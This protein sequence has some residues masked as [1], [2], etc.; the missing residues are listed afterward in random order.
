MPDEQAKKWRFS[1]SLKIREGWKRGRWLRDSPY[2]RALGGLKDSA[3]VGFSLVPLDK[4]DAHPHVGQG[5]HRHT[6]TFPFP[7][8]AVVVALGPGFLLRTQ[9]GELLQ[10]IAQWLETSKALMD[11]G[12]ITAFKG[13]WRRP[14]QGLNTAG[15]SIA[16]AILPPFCAPA[17]EPSVC[18]RPEG[19]Q[20]SGCQHAS[21]KVR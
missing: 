21:K 9:P 13:D 12:I 2:V 19:W 7:A 15:T 5:A 1:Y 6:V 11:F 3:L 16:L 8:F 10:A 4:D 14:R 20:R 18:L 17:G